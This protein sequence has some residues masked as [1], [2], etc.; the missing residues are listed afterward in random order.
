MTLEVMSAQIANII[1]ALASQGQAFILGHA[2]GNFIARITAKF[3]P[4][5]VRGVV[6]AA[7]QGESVPKAISITPFIAGNPS[8][9]VGQRLAALMLGFFAPSHGELARTWLDGWYPATLS[10]QERAVNM[11]GGLK[12][13]AFWDLGG[14]TN[15]LEIIPADD[16]FKTHEQWNQMRDLLGHL[17]T[18]VIVNEASHALFPEQSE[19]VAQRV[20]AWMG[21]W[22]QNITS[23][24]SVVTE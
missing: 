12:K 24:G 1:K 5:V 10:M 20:I 21:T 8:V 4:D 16:P 18:S 22:T 15:V 2:F 3:H 6:L 23:S 14:R 9:T 13:E 19:E 7:A 17:C 11:P